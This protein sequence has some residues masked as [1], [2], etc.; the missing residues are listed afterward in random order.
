MASDY[1]IRIATS[2]DAT[3]LAEMRRQMFLDMG[4]PDDDRLRRVV[5]AFID[6]VADAS[7]AGRYLS[8]LVEAESGVPIANAGLLLIEWPPNSRDL[9]PLRGY[10][11]NVWTH[12]EHRRRGIARKLMDIVM[13]E[14]RQ[15][16]I[17]VLALH[18]SDTGRQLYEQLGFRQS[19]EM[20][21]VEPE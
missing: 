21:Y 13:A 18:A 6:W 7:R 11:M 8:W 15:R 2:N 3:V 9:T 17:R 10:V 4:K 1:R 5:Q 16:R 20:L 19:R 14:A 12:P